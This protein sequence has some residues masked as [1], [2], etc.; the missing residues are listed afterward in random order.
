M[1][2]IDTH[3]HIYSPDEVRHPP[4]DN[5]LRPPGGRFSAGR[6]TGCGSAAG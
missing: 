3:A 5:P 1:L 6:P 2:L 4:I